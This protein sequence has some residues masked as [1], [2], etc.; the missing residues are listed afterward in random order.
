MPPGVSNYLIEKVFLLFF[1]KKRRFF[2]STYAQR[3]TSWML[4]TP[5]RGQTPKGPAPPMTMRAGSEWR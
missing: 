1:F 3:L 4:L 2:L 5:V